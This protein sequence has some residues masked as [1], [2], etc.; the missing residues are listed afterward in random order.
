MV[1]EHIEQFKYTPLDT[2][3]L[4]QLPPEALEQAMMSNPQL[5][6]INEL[7]GKYDE[8]SQLQT[9]E[10]DTYE[11]MPSELKAGFE[12]SQEQGILLQAT[13]IGFKSEKIIK[14]IVN[15]P[16]VQ[17][18][19]IKNIYIDPTCKGDIDKA[20]FIIYGFE[21]SISDL[22]KSGKYKNLD[23]LSQ[24]IINDDG[25]YSNQ[26]D[27]KFKDT[28]R[29]KLVVYEYWGY[30]DI[31]GNGITSPIL[32]TWVGDTL[33]GMEH[34]P[35]PDGKPP[36]VVFTFMP[37]EDS[38]YGSPNA[39]LLGDNQEILG[40]VTRGMIDLLGK[41]ANSQTGYAKNFLDATNKHRFLQGMDYE[42]NQG[43]DPRVHVHTHKYP[44][45]PQSAMY[46][47]N[48]MN[49][50][51]ESL[52][53]VKA[54]SNSGISASSLGDVAVGIRGVLD[55]VSKREM[56][57]L[58]RISNGFITLGR[59]IISMNSEF[60][61]EEEIV[62]ITNTEFIKVRRDD[63]AGEYDLT[64]TISTAEAD[65]SK[66]QQLAFLLQTIGNSMGMGLNQ[67]ILSE[68]ASLRKMPDLAKAIIDY[69]EEPD[70]TQQQMRELELQKLQAEVEL[71]KA[72]A[73]EATAK[74][75][76]QGAKVSVEQARA[77]NLQAQADNTNIS[78]TKNIDGSKHIED[79]QKQDLIN[80]VIR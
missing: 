13:S 38:I 58:R 51:A 71:L 30:W 17:V 28:A 22:K 39:E 4:Q 26:S 18:C 47:V 61:S 21:S 7:Q 14:P 52:S 5:A 1:E 65:E 46:M 3:L 69:S 80:M 6:Q 23:Y 55:A 9:N 32:A 70:E 45:I 76:V 73:Q 67:M 16:T 15:K 37:E 59:K 31:D 44:E 53:G 20:Q 29:R 10:P 77:E 54:F 41:S 12:M 75:Q 40:A 48:L 68:I 34:N 2:S 63:L 66:A 57:I 78:T 11:Q 60:L 19:D 24:A 64:L 72:E 49:N 50:E 74:A 62:R 27:F 25:T 36:F 42:Y 43:F 33:I 56:S 8:L 35:F 79:M